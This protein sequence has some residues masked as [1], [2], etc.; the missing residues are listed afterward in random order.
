MVEQTTQVCPP[1]KKLSK[2]LKKVNTFE[3]AFSKEERERGEEE[4]AATTMQKSKE[5]RRRR[6]NRRDWIYKFINWRNLYVKKI[7]FF[8]FFDNSKQTPLCGGLNPGRLGRCQKLPPSHK[9]W[10]KKKKKLIFR[11][12]TDENNYEYLIIL[13]LSWA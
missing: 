5:R 13:T 9:A 4:K 8:F 1:I 11:H 10:F 3:K 7:E 2:T 6:L 12:F